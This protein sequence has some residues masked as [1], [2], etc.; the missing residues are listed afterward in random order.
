MQIEFKSPTPIA[1][2]QPFALNQPL[3]IDIEPSYSC[4]LRCRMCH[5]TYMKNQKPKHLDVDR[6]DWSFVRDREISLG[7]LFEPT[8]NP[9]FNK[10]IGDLNKNDA[11]ISLTTN[12][13]NLSRNNLSN[14]Y[15]S[16]LNLVYFSFDG[17][18]KET[19]EYIR[20]R[21][22]YERVV[23]NIKNFIE[24]HQNSEATFIV[25]FTVCKSN[26]EEIIP[27]IDLWDSLGVHTLGLIVMVSRDKYLF[28]TENSLVDD[29]NRYEETLE[30]AANHLIE[31]HYQIALSAPYF[32]KPEVIEKYS[33][34][35]AGPGLIVADKSQIRKQLPQTYSLH[36][37]Y[38][39]GES[40]I[41]HQT[42]RS[43]LTTA[44]IDYDAN[45]YICQTIKIG[46]LYENTFDEIWNSRKRE[47][48]LSQLISNPE[49]CNSCDYFKFCVNAKEIDYEK[50]ESFSSQS[51]SSG[52][53]RTLEKPLID[54]G[55]QGFNLL[56]VEN[57]FYAIPQIEGEFSLERIENKDYSTFYTADNEATLRHQILSDRSRPQ[58][59]PAVQ[60][61]D[62]GYQKFN[63]LEVENRFY[64]IPQSEGKFSLER[65]QKQDYSVLF[66]AENESILR[67]RISEYHI[68]L[69]SHPRVILKK[70]IKRILKG[71][72]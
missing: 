16:K 33:R 37:Y 44:R 17:A 66:S 60:L 47:Q 30:A 65:V 15:N 64:A 62:E 71:L 51:F 8:I 59:P 13:F 25:N 58:M 18:S 38:G 3:F 7:S 26:I 14:L 50:E 1:L 11:R 63:I 20:Q 28:F 67:A 32:A 12:A 55:F 9:A 57:R 43:P 46:N 23:A 54:E 35:V 24:Q 42:C 52:T 56:E 36:Q 69:N 72:R 48:A 34:H 41:P 29:M 21:S 40:P 31:N 27:A 39:Y 4:N 10:L 68:R 22:R 5:V 53:V 61:I 19:Y 49:Q 2:N 70:T 6:I 45:V